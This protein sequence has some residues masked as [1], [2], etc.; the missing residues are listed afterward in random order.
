[1]SKITKKAQTVYFFYMYLTK[2][3]TSHLTNC[4]YCDYPFRHLNC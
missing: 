1:M 4:I 3:I 2:L